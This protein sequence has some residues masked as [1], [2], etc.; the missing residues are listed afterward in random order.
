MEY[1]RENGDAFAIP[2]FGEKSLLSFFEL[3]LSAN[4]PSPFRYSANLESESQLLVLQHI[5]STLPSLEAP[6]DDPLQTFKRLSTDQ[7]DTAHFSYG[8]LED[9]EPLEESSS[10]ASESGHNAISDGLEDLWSAKGILEPGKPPV[11]IKSW[12]RFHDKSFKEPRNVYISEAGPRVLDAALELWVKQSIDAS[13]DYRPAIFLPSNVV[14]SS[15]IQLAL[16]RESA[17][18]RYEEKQKNFQPV[19]ENIRVSGFTSESFDSVTAALIT[20]GSQIRQAKTFV[21]TVQ[22]S[23][24]ATSLSVAL[25]S[26]IDIIVSALEAQLGTPLASTYTLLQLQAL[27]QESSILLEW[28]SEII[29]KAERLTT[30]DELLSTLFDSM[31]YLEYAAPRFQPIINQLLAHVSRPWLDSYENSLGLR[32]N[33]ASTFISVEDDVG[34]L[35]ERRPELGAKAGAKVRNS[36]FP[37]MPSFIG[38]DNVEAL[39]EMKQS[40][41]LLRMHE[42]EH[43]LARSQ[44]PFQPPS[45]QWQFS[46][47]DIEEIQAKAQKFEAD[48]LG[49]LK[50]Y[51][52]L[53]TFSSSQTQCA[54][55][56]VPV[57]GYSETDAFSTGPISQP[58]TPLPSLLS[59]C[60]S[61]LSTTVSQILNNNHQAPHPLSAPPTSLLLNLSFQPILSAQSR[62]LSHSTLLLL[63]RTHSLR[64]HL[65]L[66]HSYPL[67]ADGAFLVRLTH[68]L[69]DPSLA[70][71]AYQKGSTRSGTAGLQLGARETSWP[72]ASSE[73]RIALIGILTESYHGSAEANGM[74]DSDQGGLPGDLSFAIRNDMSVAELEKCMNKDGLEALDFLKIHYRPPKP[75][76]VVITEI[77]LEKYEQVSQLLLRGA[78]VGFVVREL[79]RREWKD[80]KER[81]RHGLVQRFRIDANHFVTTV[82]GYFGDRIAELWTA[83]EERLDGIEQSTRYYEV[84]RQMEGV[85]RLRAL[86]EE[87]LDRILAACLLRKRQ[88][89]VMR[90]LEDI[91]GLVLEFAGV[92]RDGGDTVLGQTATDGGGKNAV[93]NLYEAFRKK[94]RVFVTVCRG[95]Q[96]QKSIV[97]KENLFGVGKRGEERGNGIGRL[98]LGLEMNGWYM[99]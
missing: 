31:Q 78:R 12:E 54:E 66:L 30:N 76:D 55:Q 97:G 23:P 2:D 38:S 68:A 98:V 83:F 94:V 21:E 47:Q 60:V 28:L 89:L 96:D 29:K 80:K 70:S 93:E 57:G 49:T 34:Q 85:Y 20:H 77:V 24:R 37:M 33:D 81:A 59:P 72:P 74:R 65:R 45:L 86:H 9:I 95:L 90:L 64:T 44:L 8:P 58:D 75:L 79:V 43:P 26:G 91:L 53:G 84:G 36:S 19:M 41:N 11:D 5:S 15:L 42:P 52:T 13:S 3:Q 46:W 50:E 14:L 39:L 56:S 18:F 35:K 7:Q 71:A 62:L 48:V 16:G 87:V 32:A 4:S 69:F 92:V 40:L 73:L 10:S 6:S 63:F 22:K 17:L 99:R 51:D 88:E 61:A 82:F 67:F 1:D 27:L 25:A